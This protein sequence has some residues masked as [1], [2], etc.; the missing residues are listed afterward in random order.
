MGIADDAVAAAAVGVGVGVGGAGVVDD[1]GI[2]AEIAFAVAVGVVI[3]VVVVVT[4]GQR[5]AS[6]VGGDGLCAVGVEELCHVGA[7]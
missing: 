5:S 6:E 2:V 1:A 4:P 3:G 7:F